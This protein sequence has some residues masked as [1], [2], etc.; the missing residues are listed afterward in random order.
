MIKLLMGGSPCTHWSIAQT[1]NRETEPSGL[2][3]ELF[4]NYI[5]AWRRFRP[6]YFLYENN[7]S[8]AKAIRNQI[9]REFCRPFAE[10]DDWDLVWACEDDRHAWWR[11]RHTSGVEKTITR[12]LINSAL[13]SAQNRERYY[14]TDIPD[15]DLP[16]DRGILLR[17]VLDDAISDRN[18]ACTLRASAGTKQGLYD[19][20]RHV[21][22]GGRFGY[23]GVFKP[24]RAGAYP[25]NAG[26]LVDSQSRR[27]YS[28]D[29]KAAT[30]CASASGGST[31]TSS[32]ATGLYAVPASAA[33]RGRE[34]GTALEIRDDGRSN[35]II[36]NHQQRMVVEAFL[37]PEATVAGYTE[38][39][40]GDCVDLAVPS[41]K[42]RRGRNMKDKA[43]CLTTDSQFYQ[44]CGTMARPV[45]LVKDGYI[46]IK[47]KDY[48]IKLAEGRYII[49]KLS[50]AECM[51]LQT[52][53]T[54]YQFPV[55]DT[56]AYR[57]LGN[58]W[59]CEVIARLLG[60]IPGISGAAV[61]VLSMYDGMACA[62]IA[63][64]L[65]GAEV[66]RYRATEIDKYAIKTSRHN[67]PDIVHL[68]DAFGV[69]EGGD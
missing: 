22:S 56:Q 44:Y 50:V 53:P 2:G 30:I 64:G 46:C 51:R 59:T 9:D 13:V 65:A 28:T 29:G 15:V 14:W 24:V 61:D 8:M 1:K 25:N 4:L 42:T 27:I 40:P 45:Y 67:F 60:Y 49:R 47:G 37:V 57:M 3:W 62:R 58:G 35:A 23:M 17:D 63:L 12:I 54:W 11:Y 7:K 20:V 21:E 33:W 16:E 68:G 5:I 48:P 38:V 66:T 19:N 10:G 43:N 55:S 39:L 6:D 69:R 26:E 32:Q 41:S 52:V 34:G 18:K 31:D 36:A